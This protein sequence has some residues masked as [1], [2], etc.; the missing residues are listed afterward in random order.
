VT[1]AFL[2]GAGLAAEDPLSSAGTAVTV[3]IFPGHVQDRAALARRCSRSR[4]PT[5]R[6]PIAAST[7]PA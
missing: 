3:G 1:A 7:A 4:E 5:W 6:A 2:P